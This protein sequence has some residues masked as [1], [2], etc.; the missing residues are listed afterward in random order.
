MRIHC[1]ICHH[2]VTSLLEHYKQV[3]P[4]EYDQYLIM[5]GENNGR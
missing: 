1:I 4:K 2:V 3:H 5:N